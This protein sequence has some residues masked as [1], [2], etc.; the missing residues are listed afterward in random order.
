MSNKNE[1]VEMSGNEESN[2]KINDETESLPVQQSKLER[3]QRLHFKTVAEHGVRLPTYEES[4][5][6]HAKFMRKL[7][8]TDQ[9]VTTNDVNTELRLE[10]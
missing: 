6:N 9:E 3:P 4:Q 7:P 2:G 10:R 8:D 1:F 5:A